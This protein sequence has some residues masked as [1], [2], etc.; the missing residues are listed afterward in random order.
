VRAGLY[1]LSATGALVIKTAG[2]Q[3]SPF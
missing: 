1:A 2:R 3:F